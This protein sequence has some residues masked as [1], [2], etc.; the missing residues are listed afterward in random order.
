MFKEYNLCKSGAGGISEQFQ[1]KQLSFQR[2]GWREIN[3]KCLLR[4]DLG[5]HIYPNC[6]PYPSSHTPVRL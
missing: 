1:R 5:I 4:G 6:Q 3:V 2:G